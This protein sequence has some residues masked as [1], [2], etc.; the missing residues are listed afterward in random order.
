MVSTHTLCST[1]YPTPPSAYPIPP[2]VTF[3]NQSLD[4][5]FRQ[6]QTSHRAT[7]LRPIAAVEAR[8]T[9]QRSVTKSPH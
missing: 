8:R 9:T 2:S 5:P 1:S 3:P 6:P 7:F 4:F